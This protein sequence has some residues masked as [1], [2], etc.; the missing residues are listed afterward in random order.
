MMVIYIVTWS[1]I[2][3][4]LKVAKSLFEDGISLFSIPQPTSKQI[5]LVNFGQFWAKAD[6]QNILT[7]RMVT[8][9]PDP[10][11]GFNKWDFLL[12]Q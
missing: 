7:H 9:C 10:G 12:L 5:L 3:H 4:N 8:L 11:S 2:G 6:V 1:S